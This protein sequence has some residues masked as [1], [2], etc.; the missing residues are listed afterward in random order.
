[1]GPWQNAIL[2]LGFR[3]KHGLVGVAHRWQSVIPTPTVCLNGASRINVGSDKRDQL[4]GRARVD[5]LRPKS[6]QIAPLSLDGHGYDALVL[7]TAAAL[8]AAFTAQVKFI[9][10]HMSRKSFAALPDRTTAQVLQPAPFRMV[11]SQPQQIFQVD[12][13]DPGLASGKPPHRFKEGPHGL[14]GAMQNR[15]C[16]NRLVVF[17]SA[18]DAALSGTH[19]TTAVPATWAVR[20]LRPPHPKKILAAGLLLRKAFV[21]L[22]LVIREIFGNDKLAHHWPPHVGLEASLSPN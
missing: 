3:L 10:L 2:V 22:L 9:H 4:N 5:D 7:N 16:G 14:F 20:P 8:A 18:T 17:P 6:A 19:P 12:G 21:K 15:G 11:A 13:V 1:M